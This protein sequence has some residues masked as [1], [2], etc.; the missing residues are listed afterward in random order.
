MERLYGQ[1]L[2]PR[3]SNTDPSPPN[4]PGTSPSQTLLALEHA[5]QHGIVHRDI[6]PGNIF[7]CQD[8]TLKVTDFGIAHAAGEVRLTGTGAQL[9]TP[10]YMSPEQVEGAVSDGRTDLYSVGIV[11][12]EML[13]GDVPFRAE[14]PLSVM[15]QQVTRAAPSLPAGV[16]VVL[17]ACGGSCVGEV[18]GGALCVGVSDARSTGRKGGAGSNLLLLSSP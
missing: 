13:T 14:T 16:P 1:T 6:K 8:G 5:H 9:G 15:H 10:E 11:L 18:A 12:Y 4:K 17:G 7:L 3:R 2:S